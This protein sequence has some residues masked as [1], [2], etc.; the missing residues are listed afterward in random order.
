VDS[1]VLYHD[2]YQAYHFGPE[3]P[4]SP[5][6]QAMLVDLLRALDAWAP[7]TTPPVATRDDIL[8]VHAESLVEQV[9]AAAEGTPRPSARQFGLDTADV[10]VFDDMD[11]ATRGLVGGT[12]YGA[13]CIAEGTADR[14]LQLGGGLHHARRELASGFCVYNDLSVA[15][16]ALREAGLRVAYLDIDVHHGDGVQWIHYDDPDVLTLSL[17]ESGRYL[18]PGT[19]GVSELGDEPGHGLSLNVPLEPYTEDESYRECFNRVVPYAIE[20]FAPDVLVAQCGADAHF[21]DPLADLMLTTPMYERLFRQ[22]I[23]LA[24]THAQGRLLLTLGG[25]YRFDATVRVWAMLYLIA[26]GLDLPDALPAGWR[27]TW[28]ARLNTSLTPTLH[29]APQDF[30]VPRHDTIVEQNRR[31]SKRLMEMI[32]P[33]WY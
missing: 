27:A 9:E 25:G 26:N 28:E 24:E 32:A 2:R 7:T 3:H 31:V 14:V 30:D 12:L 1:L 19:G 10:P 17:H 5:Q 20:H 23:D 6:R 8:R 29:D 4:F 16:H 13:R 11:T 21:S 33:L 18:F 15:I 22:I